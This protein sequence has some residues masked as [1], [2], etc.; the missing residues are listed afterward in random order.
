MTS[1]VEFVRPDTT[2]S[3]LATCMITGRRRS[4][5]VVEGRRVVGMVTRRDLVE[6]MASTD[7]QIAARVGRRLELA[8][9]PHRWLA[10]VQAGVVPAGNGRPEN[11]EEVVQLVESVPGVVR[12]TLSG[13]LPAGGA[14]AGR[15]GSASAAAVG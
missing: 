5:P 4:V 6:T 9:G 2:L 13:P 7:N 8:G 12:V 3:A 15:H 14:V 1:P 11:E 10:R